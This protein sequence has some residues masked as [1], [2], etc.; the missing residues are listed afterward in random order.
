MNISYTQINMKGVLLVVLIVSTLLTIAAVVYAFHCGCGVEGFEG[1]S[2]VRQT[3][4]K[5][6]AQS[7]NALLA[8]M[9]KL[10]R[11]N[12]F[13]ANPK[14]WKERIEMFSMT[15]MDL[16]RKHLQEQADKS[17]A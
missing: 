4:E 7:G 12:G 16:A 6:K 10:K 8:L 13:L 3:L 11:M 5:A 9:G 2:N 1:G 14:N 15:P 17:K